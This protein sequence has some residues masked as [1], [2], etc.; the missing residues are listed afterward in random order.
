MSSTNFKFLAAAI[1]VVLGVVAGYNHKSTV[2]RLFYL[3]FELGMR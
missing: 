3:H 2:E 1:V